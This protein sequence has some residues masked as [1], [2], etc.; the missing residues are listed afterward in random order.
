MV[1]VVSSKMEDEAQAAIWGWENFFLEIVRFVQSSERQFEAHANHQYTEYVLERLAMMTQSIH[2]IRQQLEREQNGTTLLNS[3][4]E[5]LDLLP[6]LASKW[7]EH[8]NDIEVRLLASQYQ[9]PLRHSA[10][11][12]RPRFHVTKEQ[13]EFLRS[14]SF[15]WSS[16]SKMLGVS[17][18]TIYRRRVQYGLIVEPSQFVTN[19]RLMQIVYRLRQELPDIG[20]SMFAGRLRAMGLRVTRHR[21]REA[22]R[23][24]DPLNTA[25]RWHTLTNRRPYSVPGPNSLWHIGMYVAFK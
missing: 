21:I 9:L 17:R 2:S 25:L 1:V 11:R 22:I 13:L 12:G 4:G 24:S 23:K 5:L 18:M 8:F 7:Q 19:G 16:I 20:Q 15:S 10:G 3:L 14:L 6:Q